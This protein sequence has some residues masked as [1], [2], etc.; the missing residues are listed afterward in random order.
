MM[1]MI[2]LVDIDAHDES[3]AVACGK[4]VMATVSSAGRA[5]IEENDL[6][7]QQWDEMH[8][9]LSR[10]GVSLEYD[11]ELGYPVAVA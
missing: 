4:V 1:K 6:T 8:Q 11:H 10:R 7:E 3:Y 5:M 2:K 9:Y